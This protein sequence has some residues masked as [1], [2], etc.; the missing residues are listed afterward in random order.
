VLTSS[1]L[2]A[3]RRDTEQAYCETENA[4]VKSSF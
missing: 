1:P 3:C 4:E 2:A